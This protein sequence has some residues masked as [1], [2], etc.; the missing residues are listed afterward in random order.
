MDYILHSQYERQRRRWKRRSRSFSSSEEI[1]DD[2]A[3]MCM[4]VPEV[5]YDVPVSLELARQP[6]KGKYMWLSIV[7]YRESREQIKYLISGLHR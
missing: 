5:V 3:D 1:T 2:E 7:G 6:Q 4:K